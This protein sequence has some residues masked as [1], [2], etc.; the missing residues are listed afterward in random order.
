MGLSIFLGC[1]DVKPGVSSQ[2]PLYLQGDAPGEKPNIAGNL[3]ATAIK[4]MESLDFVFYPLKLINKN[5][6]AELDFSKEKID[7]PGILTLY[8]EG[9][10]DQFLIGTMRGSTIKTFIFSRVKETYDAELQVAGLKYDMRFV[11]GIS[12]INTISDER[13]NPLEDDKNYKVAISDF[14][15]FNGSTFPS[16]K[17]R[18]GLQGRFRRQNKLISARQTLKNYLEQGNLNNELFYDQRAVVKNIV[19]GDAGELS[20][21]EIQGESFLSPFYGYK[22]RT[23]GIVTAIAMGDWYPGGTQLIIQSP[24]DDGNPLTSEAVS[25]YVPEEL[26]KIKLGDALKVSGVIYE[27][28]LGS[29][30]SRTIIREVDGIDVVSHDNPLPAPVRLGEGL[31]EYPTQTVSSFRGNLNLK[32]KLERTDGIDFWESVEDMRVTVIAPRVV[33]FRGGKE[34]FASLDP[35]PYLNLYLVA[36]NASGSQDEESQTAAG[37]IIIDVE[38]GDFNPQILQLSTGPFTRGMDS[39]T[40]YNIGDV[41]EG[42][43]TGNI[44]YD[45]NLFGDGNYTFVLP[46]EQP[47]ILTLQKKNAALTALKSRPKSSLNKLP[48]HLRV[49]TF[50]VEN[51]SGNQFSRIIELGKA[52]SSQLLCPEIINFVEI[53]DVNGEDFSG[54]AKGNT[55][56]KR[57][58]DVLNCPGTNYLPLNID[59][60]VHAEGGQPGGNIRVAMIYDAKS[61]L[62]TPRGEAGPF[63]ETLVMPDG[64]L[65]VNPG[66]VFPNDPV[67]ATTRKSIVAEFSFAGETIFIIGNHFN[68]KLGDSSRWGA[69]QPPF[70]G[71]ENMRSNIADRINYFV[72]ILHLKNPKAH[73]IVLGDFN[74]YMIENALKILEG[75]VLTNLMAQD[76]IL[77]KAERYTTNY[78]GNS[79]PL[80]YIFIS[81][82]LFDK[83]PELEI[84]HFNSDYMGRLSDHD[85]VI[86]RFNFSQ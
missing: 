13:G 53:Q 21:P 45:K 20:I 27:D 81:N 84:P 3:M 36:K 48:D 70:L 28:M 25:I 35:K 40:S 34:K 69:N 11:G 38:K 33:G 6:V 49:A 80:D 76:Q 57:I 78:N 43:L 2:E 26:V 55:T 19:K 24:K 31:Y 59:P 75:K 68:S 22:V 65:S 60:I 50:N 67:F 73:I 8:P 52:I 32:P 54:D 30:L 37:G 46:Q 41:I 29:G 17:Y 23:S 77:P 5:S 51:L 86:A 82:S 61:V 1:H 16:Y 14:Y 10:E 66:R 58:I 74:A 9:T 39:E 4:Q 71:S 18:N 64:S 62:F 56:L 72:N 15:Y 79:Q 85:P 42:E 63:T 12:T 83:S 44:I 47:A 7:I